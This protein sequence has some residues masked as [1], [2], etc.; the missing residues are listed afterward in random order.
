M[1]RNYKEEYRK[2]HDD[3]KAIRDRAATNKIRRLLE[4]KGRVKKGDG[5][6]VNHKDGNQQNN[7]PSNIEVISESENKADVKGKRKRAKKGKK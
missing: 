1:A 2:F 3:R 4:K 6:N 5:K 7:D